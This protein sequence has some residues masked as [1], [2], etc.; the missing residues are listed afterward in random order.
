M[1]LNF[2]L[3]SGALFYPFTFLIT[4]LITEIFSKDKA[5]FCV[6]LGLSLNIFAALTIAFMNYL[7]ATSW[8]KLDNVLFHQVFGMYGAAFLALAFAC[9]FSQ[10][11]DII[12]YITIKK[13]TKD[14]YLWLRNNI[15][16][17]IALLIDTTLVISVMALFGA[18]PNEQ[19]WSLIFNSYRF[20][21]MITFLSTPLFMLWLSL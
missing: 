8:S 6:K 9:Y 7:P 5:S 15:S 4:D 14:K 11:I 20:K 12:I 19:K 16:T 3:S 2:E 17:S 18:L 1:F 21:L 13:L 10:N